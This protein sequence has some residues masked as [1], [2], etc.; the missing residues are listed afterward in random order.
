VTLRRPCCHAAPAVGSIAEATIFELF[1]PSVSGLLASLPS[2]LP[3]ITKDDINRYNAVFITVTP[4]ST[5]R[6]QFDIYDR[7]GK[8][9]HRDIFNAS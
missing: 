2:L 7:T 4:G 5:A 1:P 8:L 3:Q 9:L 6:A